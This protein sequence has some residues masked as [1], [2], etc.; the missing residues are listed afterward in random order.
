MKGNESRDK[1]GAEERR[2]MSDIHMFF[3]VVDDSRYKI[4]VRAYIKRKKIVCTLHTGKTWCVPKGWYLV[5]GA[6]F[7]RKKMIGGR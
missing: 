6:S 1:R 2:A 7:V 4:R 5:P 3:V